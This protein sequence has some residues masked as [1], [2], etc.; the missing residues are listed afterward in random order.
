MQCGPD[1]ESAM[2]RV[3]SD[4]PWPNSTWTNSPTQMRHRD[5]PSKYP[6]ST[7]WCDREKSKVN[8]IKSLCQ[9]GGGGICLRGTSTSFGRRDF[10]KWEN[11]LIRFRIAFPFPMRFKVQLCYREAGVELG[12]HCLGRQLCELW[13][14]MP[15][16]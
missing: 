15:C 6:E 11:Q 1:A 7:Q 3:N 16:F 8:T 4:S 2:M 5:S 13:W 9:G 14:H 12:R 10:V